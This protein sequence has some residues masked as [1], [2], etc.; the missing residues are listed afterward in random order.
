MGLYASRLGRP[1]D[2]VHLDLETHW[3]GICD[4]FFRQL[5]PRKRSLPGGNW[6]E[7]FMLLRRRE[8]RNPRKEQG[9]FSSQ[10]VLN[11]CLFRPVVVFER[12]N[13]EF[14]FITAL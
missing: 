12:A 8:R 14:N 4:Y 10:A 1:N 6:F 9:T 5:A 11:D 13:D 3:Q 7:G 2:F